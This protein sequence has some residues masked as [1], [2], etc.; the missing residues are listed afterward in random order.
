MSIIFICLIQYTTNQSNDY[1][2]YDG[3]CTYDYNPDYD[4]YYS[5]CY[6]SGAVIAGAVIGVL[7]LVCTPC[8]LICVVICC[9]LFIP[10][11]ILFNSRN[12]STAYTTATSTTTE[13][14]QPLIV[15]AYQ[16]QININPGGYYP[17]PPQAPIYNN[18][19]QP[20]YTDVHAP[21]TAPPPYVNTAHQP[22]YY[23]PQK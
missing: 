3:Y 2:S 17:P 12:N 18:P 14:T 13:I 10:G 1:Y 9:C 15:P 16:Q 4:E 22:E 19:P 7:C 8:V 5:Y 23:P 11:C 20:S 6:D 21:I